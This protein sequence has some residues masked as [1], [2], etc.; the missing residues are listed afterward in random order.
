[1]LTGMVGARPAVSPRIDPA[2]VSL[3]GVLDVEINRYR[4]DRNSLK[5]RGGQPFTGFLISKGTRYYSP[6]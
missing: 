2:A 3:E 4:R 5:E 6:P 1:M